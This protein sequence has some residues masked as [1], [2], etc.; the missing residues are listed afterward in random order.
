M[1][2][3]SKYVPC[4]QLLTTAQIQSLSPASCFLYSSIWNRM[5]MRDAIEVSILDADAVSLSRSTPE[6]LLK[7]QSE[8]HRAGLLDIEPV[9]NPKLR[10]GEQRT[11]YVLP[12][13]ESNND[14]DMRR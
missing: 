14:I 8:L 9:V 3:E 6:L 1:S 4:H 5:R 7:V 10:E 12:A 11:R 2:K 13:S